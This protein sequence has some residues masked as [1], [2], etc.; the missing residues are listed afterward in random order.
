MG[1]LCLLNAGRRRS[2]CRLVDSVV[3]VQ[4]LASSTIMLDLCPACRRLPWNTT[5]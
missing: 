3:Y 1:A 2:Y 5:S 4:Y